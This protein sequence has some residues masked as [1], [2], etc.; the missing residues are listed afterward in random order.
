MMKLR[1]SPRTMPHNSNSHRPLS[2]HTL[3]LRHLHSILIRCPYLPR[4]KLRLT[5]PKYSCQRRLPILHLYLSAHWTRTL[6]RLIPLQRNMKYWGYP[7]TPHNNNCLRRLR[8]TLRPN[9]ILRRNRHYQ[10][11]L[12][13]SIY[14]KYPGPMDLR[15]LLRRQCHP[16]PLFCFPLP[17]PLHHR[18]CH[19]SSLTISARNR[20]QQP[21]W[22]KLRCR[23][24][25]L[26]PVLLLQRPHRLYSSPHY[27][28]F[29]CIIFPESPR[30][31]R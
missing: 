28:Y 21:N 22:P 17:L 5:H 20:L 30:R 15:R 13:G 7:L 31:P 24:N 29:P 26:S 9:I 6:L 14:R 19:H 27:T 3:H 16:D 23:Q 11:P 12:C 8:L 2:S 10:P 1:L 18:S 25:S 4:R